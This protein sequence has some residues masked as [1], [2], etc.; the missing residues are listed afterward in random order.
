[1]R[2]GTVSAALAV[3]MV[4]IA[5]GPAAAASYAENRA[6]ATRADRGELIVLDLYGSYTDMGREEAELLGATATVAAELYTDHWDGLVQHRGLLGWFVN[7]LVIPFWGSAG[8]WRDDSGFFAEG[9]GIARALTRPRDSDGVRL[10]YGAVYGGASTAFA[11]TRG[12]TADGGAILGR[13]V[14]WSDDTGRRRPV[15]RRY[16]PDNGDFVHLT[17]SWP[18]VFVPIVGLNAAGLAISMNFFDADDMLSLGFPRILYRRLLQRARTVGEALAM[19]AEPGN[20]GGASILV[21]ADARGDIAVAECTASRCAVFRPTD[22]WVAQANHTRTPDMHD[23]DRGRAPDSLRRQA[24]M[25]DAVGR[26]AGAITPAVASE[27]LRDRANSRFMNDS[28]VANLRVLNPVIVQPATRTLW[29]STSMQPIAPFGALVPFTVDGSTPAAPTLPADPGLGDGTLARQVEVV[30]AMQQAERLYETGRVGDAGALWDRMA[31]E[32][33]DL[34]EPHRLAW[35]RARTR[36]SSGRLAEAEA[37][38]G[39]ADVDA[40]PFEVRAYAIT[41]RGMIADRAERRRAA[42]D[43]YD[44]AATFLDAHPE[45]DAPDLI[46]PIRAWIGAG[47][48]QPA[49]GGRLPPLPDLQAIPR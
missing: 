42:L 45:Y 28:T 16:H 6:R 30:A 36:W 5:A 31:F 23:H 27:I 21:L 48:A 10:V 34:L 24:A 29:H 25:A 41:A 1:M 14:D 49:T 20:R 11:A 19:L 9:A 26:H 17:A 39:A 35:A 47:R 3:M 33:P 2:A 46:D 12:A 8:G 44:R 38:L 13:N 4:A 43:Q 40:A 37:F 15:L 7:A 32:A 22:D 18:L